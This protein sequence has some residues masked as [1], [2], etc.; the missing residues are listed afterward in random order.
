MVQQVVTSHNGTILL[1]IQGKEPTSRR[2]FVAEIEGHQCTFAY[3]TK[4]QG[5]VSRWVKVVTFICPQR[6][7]IFSTR[8][9]MMIVQAFQCMMNLVEIIL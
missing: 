2:A 1:Q 8:G 5:K 6:R 9:F 4:R 7:E 3:L